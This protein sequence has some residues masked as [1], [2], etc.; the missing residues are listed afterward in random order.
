[1]K[2]PKSSHHISAECKKQQPS[3]A[4]EGKKKR[5][6]ERKRETPLPPPE[7]EA[8]PVWKLTALITL[9]LYV[10]GTLYTE[11]CAPP[12]NRFYGCAR[13]CVRACACASPLGRAALGEVGIEHGCRHGDHHCDDRHPGAP[14]ALSRRQET[15]GQWSVHS[16]DT[17]RD[18]WSE[19]CKPRAPPPP[20]IPL[21]PRQFRLLLRYFSRPPLTTPPVLSCIWTVKRLPT[22][23]L[24]RHAL[25]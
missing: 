23:P 15:Q 25:V 22:P 10:H 7:K 20:N 6:R 1:M 8:S 11:S 21:F 3:A 4:A 18:P 17:R 2:K 24:L 16:R 13:V 19:P 14:A 12:H 5:E 9:H